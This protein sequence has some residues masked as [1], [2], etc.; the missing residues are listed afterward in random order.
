[1]LDLADGTPEAV[2]GEMCE[3]LLANMV[4]ESYRVEVL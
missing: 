1:E 4:I 2:I 3:K